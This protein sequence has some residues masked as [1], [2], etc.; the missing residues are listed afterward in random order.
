L[1]V[2][3]CV[4]EKRNGKCGEKLNNFSIGDLIDLHVDYQ[5]RGEVND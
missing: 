3:D 2:V 5:Y 1:L 4:I